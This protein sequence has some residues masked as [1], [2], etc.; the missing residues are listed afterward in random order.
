MQISNGPSI[1]FCCVLV[2]IRHTVLIG[3]VCRNQVRLGCGHPAFAALG[4]PAPT[5]ACAPLPV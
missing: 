4:L 1:A 5:S 3:V 2:F